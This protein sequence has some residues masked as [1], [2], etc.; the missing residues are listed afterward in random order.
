MNKE[1]IKQLALI[2]LSFLFIGIGIFNFNFDFKNEDKILEVSS[3]NYENEL[4]LGDVQLVNSEVA[5]EKGIKEFYLDE[6][7]P[8][9]THDIL[10]EKTIEE[11]KESKYFDKSIWDEYLSEIVP[12]DYI[13]NIEKDGESKKDKENE[14]SEEDYFLE[15][16]LQRDIM[17]SEILD[18]YQKML[19]S[20]EIHENQKMIAMQEIQN[21]NNIKNSI[22]ISEKLIVNKGFEKVVILENDGKINVIV[23]SDK[24][25]KEEIAQIQNII[26]RQFNVELEN[27]N[28]SNK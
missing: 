19:G 5:K 18:T 24:I 13:E 28:I 2:L 26:L 1:K 3:E 27:I 10:K 23:K 4:N 15:T 11:I 17:Y 21:I 25:S 6:E 14:K 20:S 9:K 8:N 16:K 22:M 12:N 7:D